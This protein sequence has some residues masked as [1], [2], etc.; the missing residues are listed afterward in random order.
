[1][2]R[3]TE[4][5]PA[6]GFEYLGTKKSRTRLS[7]MSFCKSVED[8]INGVV[9]ITDKS[10]VRFCAEPHDWIIVKEGCIVDVLDDAMLVTR[11]S[12]DGDA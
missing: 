8:Y 12:V 1:M 4:L 2:K 3:L 9:W 7:E 6:T 11:F 5:S 10:G